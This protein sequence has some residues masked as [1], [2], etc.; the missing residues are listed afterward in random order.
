[1]NLFFWELEIRR[2]LQSKRL[3]IK[4]SVNTDWKAK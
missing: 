3:A 4:L 2:L 1:M